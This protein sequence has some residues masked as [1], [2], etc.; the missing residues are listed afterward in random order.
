MPHSGLAPSVGAIKYT[1]VI[2]KISA[3][4]VELL[5]E[6]T[7]FSSFTAHDISSL[8]SYPD[9]AKRLAGLVDGHETSP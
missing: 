7:L 1:E 5:K 3:R 4:D 9:L 2:E 6:L 8:G